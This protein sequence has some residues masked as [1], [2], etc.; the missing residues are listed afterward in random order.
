MKK[1]L[2]AVNN[3]S[4]YSWTVRKG[5]NGPKSPEVLFFIGGG[6]SSFDTCVFLGFF[7]E[8]PFTASSSILTV[9]RRES[10]SLTSCSIASLT[11]FSLVAWYISLQ[12]FIKH[13]STSGSRTPL[14]KFLDSCEKK[15]SYR[16]SLN[17]WFL[18]F[19]LFLE[20]WFRRHFVFLKTPISSLKIFN[21]D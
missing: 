16:Y 17:R 21:I 5:Y 20:R 12:N 10:F 6:S 14:N 3:C 18:N 2:N 15:L 9:S 11:K 1:E 8:W 13:M 19:S 7:S 4:I